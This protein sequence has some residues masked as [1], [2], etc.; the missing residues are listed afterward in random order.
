M[1]FDLMVIGGGPAGYLAAERAGEAGLKTLLIEKKAVG[2]VCLHEGCIP[3]KTMLYSAKLYDQAMNSHKYGL[4][5]ENVELN[6]SAVI[7]RKN[8][9]V[10]TLLAGI[11]DTLKKHQVTVLEGQA[12][13]LGRSYDG[14]E[15]KTGEVTHTGKRLL[16]AT[17][18]VPVIPDL[19]GVNEGL[20]A[21][22]LL[23]NR[24]IL[25]LR[26]VPASLVI[27]GGGIIGL[28]MAS[29]FSSAG[30]QVTVIEMLDHIAGPTDREIGEFLMKAYQKKGVTF[31]LS[32]RVTGIAKG[33]VLYEAG[34]EIHSAAAD[35]ILMSIGRK[36]ET[37]SLGL[38]TIGV[39]T[40]RGRII[41][42]AGGRTNVSEVYAAGDVNGIS[43]LA[44]TAYREA[45]VCIHNMLGLND[46]VT[47]ESIPSV[48]YTQ[49][50]VGG[51]GE[52]EETARQKGLDYGVAKL[53]MRYSGRFL[54]ENEGG[55]GLCKV[56]IE[57]HTGRILGVHLIG[58][59]ASEIIYGA[60]I[61][62][63]KNVTVKEVKRLVF[64][65]PSVSEIIRETV[66]SYKE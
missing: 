32:A 9:V 47:Y 31:K 37:R 38:E 19:P 7:D 2:G 11:R 23:T 63:E 10:R 45:E 26:E 57:R 58:S 12:E 42:D 64:P 41:T 13:I 46:K 52:T 65:H 53:S 43:M 50:E 44:H 22:Y 61:L 6:H 3:T 56:L 15:V 54:A 4:T 66:S 29:Y 20:E 34:G 51:V 62:I 36:P 17:G 33:E 30:S 55:D 27:I 49:P 18:S 25:N 40:E 21:G 59:Y 48:I 28:E 16:L 35:K 14:Y 24:E 8:K 1:D 39:L 5:A 60:G